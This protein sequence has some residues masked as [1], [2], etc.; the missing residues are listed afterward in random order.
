MA[1]AG[2]DVSGFV[3]GALDRVA[4]VLQ[5]PERMRA[6]GQGGDFALDDLELDS[7]SRFEVMM[8]IEDALGIELDDD[9]FAG[10]T[11]FRAL[12]AMVESRVAG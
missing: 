10:V 9:D 3:L 11:T 8:Q 7:L 1:E 12:V 4:P 6:L 2:R 5:S